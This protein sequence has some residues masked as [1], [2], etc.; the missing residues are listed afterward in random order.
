MK[1]KQAELIKQLSD[2]ELYLNLVFTQIILLIVS[3]VLSIILFE[4]ISS[5]FDL[6]QFKDWR[7]LTI[8]GSAGAA[9]IFLDILMMK[10]LPES[11]HDDGG[12]NERIFKNLPVPM[13]FIVALTVGLSEE[14]LFRGIIQTHLGLFWTSLIFALI[15][16][17]YLF[18]WFLFV[19]ITV[20][21]FF[22][23]IL[24]EVTDNLLVTIFTHFLID[25]ILGIIVKNKEGSH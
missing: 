21:S 18:N 7:I 2:K 3:L 4:D 12:V 8:G 20:L 9:V 16:Y 22:I 5:F 1:N 10:L 23:G 6:F 11:Y 17:R 24:F 19:N 14:I 13:I 25:F 15:H